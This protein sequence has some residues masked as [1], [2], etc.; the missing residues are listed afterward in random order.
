MWDPASSSL[1]VLD[2]STLFV[3][4]ACVGGHLRVVRFVRHLFIQYFCKCG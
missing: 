3:V 4:A 2:T 1:I